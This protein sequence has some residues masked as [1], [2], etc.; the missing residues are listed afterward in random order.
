M[1]LKVRVIPRAK[2]NEIVSRVGSILRVK[3]CTPDIKETANRVLIDF[4]S[5]FF[6]VRTAKIF[7]RRGHKGREKIIEI[8]GKQEEELRQILD[9]IP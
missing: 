2:Q 6:E 9:N 3:L 8:D 4:L 5:D 7:L 1:I